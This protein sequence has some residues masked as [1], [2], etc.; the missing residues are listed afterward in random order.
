MDSRTLVKTLDM[1]K[2]DN[3]MYCVVYIMIDI[4]NKNYMNRPGSNSYLGQQSLS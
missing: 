1:K 2:V 4:A 3:R